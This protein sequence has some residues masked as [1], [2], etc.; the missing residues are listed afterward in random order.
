MCQEKQ[1]ITTKTV[2]AFVETLGDRQI[3]NLDDRL[4][5]WQGGTGDDVIRTAMISDIIGPN[6]LSVDCLW[7][8]RKEGALTLDRPRHVLCRHRLHGDGIPTVASASIASGKPTHPM[9]AARQ[10]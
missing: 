8:T 7:H 1:F 5:R 3:K 9:T 2:N 6:S 4:E 10:L